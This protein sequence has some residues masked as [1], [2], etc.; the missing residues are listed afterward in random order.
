MLKLEDYTQ[1][2]A[3]W[4]RQIM[5]F[6]DI[7]VFSVDTIEKMIKTDNARN[8][9]KKGYVKAGPMLN[10]TKSLLED[11]YRPFNAELSLLLKYINI[12]Y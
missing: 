2:R 3:A 4:L 1:D 10:E 11:F 7:D 9:N 6:L 8:T 5:A 12:D